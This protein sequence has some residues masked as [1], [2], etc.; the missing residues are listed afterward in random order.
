M[1]LGLSDSSQFTDTQ[2]MTMGSEERMNK[3][4]KCWMLE[5]R[6]GARVASSEERKTTSNVKLKRTKVKSE[7]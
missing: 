7:S 1:T 3:N 2:T 6:K 5:I 4:F